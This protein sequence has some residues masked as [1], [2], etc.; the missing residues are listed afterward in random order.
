MLRKENASSTNESSSVCN[1]KIADDKIL[2]LLKLVYYERKSI[3]QSARFLKLDYNQSK[4]IV[5][6]FRQK[7]LGI[8][9]EE[10]I[11]DSLSK[12][13]IE[14]VSGEID[15]IYNKLSSLNKEIEKDHKTL[16]V[17]IKSMYL[18][19]NL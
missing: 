4:K 1:E 18:L 11:L 5:K 9:I 17:L 8:E 12:K 7:K 3:K 10:E 16:S 13:Q 6:K 15:L 14:K 19:S 2:D